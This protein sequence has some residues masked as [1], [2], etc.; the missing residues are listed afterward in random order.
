MAHG[1]AVLYDVI[2]EIV[3][4]DKETNILVWELR[5]SIKRWR[6]DGPTLHPHDQSPLYEVA[7]HFEEFWTSGEP[8]PA[9]NGLYAGPGQ[10][11]EV[12]RVTLED[13][14]LQVTLRPLGLSN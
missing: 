4:W 9:H 5:P 8:L 2:G 3:S 10:R 1:Y 13:E 14:R 7:R 6:Y 12:L 11:V